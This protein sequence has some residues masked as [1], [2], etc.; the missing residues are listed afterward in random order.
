[1]IWLW[2]LCVR[3]LNA[4][5]VTMSEICRFVLRRVYYRSSAKQGTARPSSMWVLSSWVSLL[6]DCVFFFEKWMVCYSS[7]VGLFCF[8]EMLWMGGVFVSAAENTLALS[9][10]WW[11]PTL[12]SAHI[13]FWDFIHWEVQNKCDSR[14]LC[15]IHFSKQDIN[16][17]IFSP[18]FFSPKLTRVFYSSMYRWWRR[19]SM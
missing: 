17:N 14:L 9:F 2:G 18:P 16:S 12:Q 19:A 10:L 1:M 15:S 3:S 4:A 13:N 7:C 8:W 6:V 11:K 5:A